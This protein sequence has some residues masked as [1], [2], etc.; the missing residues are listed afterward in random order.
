MRITKEATDETILIELGA[1]FA[2]A[3]L[4][5]NLTQ[6]QL[7]NQA[8]VAK[9]TVERV[10]AG[11]VGAQLSGV[12][13]LCRALGIVERLEMLIPEPTPGPVEQLRLRKRQRLRA[14]GRRAT[15]TT[16]YLGL[17][18]PYPPMEV[19]ETPARTWKWGDEA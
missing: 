6:A 7:A 17:I 16:N 19:N 10:E 14:T 13:R 3:R 2:R 18:K 11:A 12:I 4:E 8:G 5:L 1:R 15:R 9:R